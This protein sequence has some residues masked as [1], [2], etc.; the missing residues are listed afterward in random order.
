MLVF[1]CFPL[2]DFNVYRYIWRVDSYLKMRRGP[3]ISFLKTSHLLDCQDA[4]SRQSAVLS[5]HWPTSDLGCSRHPSMDHSFIIELLEDFF[6]APKWGSKNRGRLDCSSTA[7]VYMFTYTLW[8]NTT[9]CKSVMIVKLWKNRLWYFIIQMLQ[10]WLNLKSFEAFELKSLNFTHS[11]K[12]FAYAISYW[13]YRT[14]S[15]I[16]YQ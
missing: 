10:I 16:Q 4:D 11:R 3:V 9:A 1:K 7:S 2:Q 13:T 14:L 5:A 15:I 6:L 8:F 12:Q